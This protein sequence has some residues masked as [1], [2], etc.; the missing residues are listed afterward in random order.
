[1]TVLL[2]YW[3]VGDDDGLALLA[4]AAVESLLGCGLVCIIT[5][6]SVAPLHQSVRTYYKE[7]LSVE[8]EFRGKKKRVFPGFWLLTETSR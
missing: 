1:M 5:I 2:C 8:S 3:S 6:L 4:A 7:I